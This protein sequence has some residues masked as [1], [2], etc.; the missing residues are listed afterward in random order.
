[1]IASVTGALARR[2]R[3][4]Y[5][6]HPER[7]R[8]LQRPVISIGNLS[9]GGTGKTPL[10]AHIARLL[11]QMGHLPAVLS[12][13]YGRPRA[14]DG[15]VVV[16][17]GRHVLAPYE[18]AG[19][20]PLMLARQ[21]P[22]CIV[23]VAADRFLAGALAERRLGCTVHLLDDGFQHLQLARALDL[24][25]VTGRDLDDR[26][27]PAGRLREPIGTIA[28]ADAVVVHAADGIAERAQTAGARRVFTMTRTIDERRGD[29]VFAFAGIGRPEGFF[30]ALAEGGWNVVG[31][32]AFPDHR[33]YGAADFARLADRAARAGASA[34]VTTE[35]DAARL[36]GLRVPTLPLIAVALAVTV[37]PAAA[38]SAMLQQACARG[39]A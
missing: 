5:A 26:V 38:F 30:D 2:R 32:M 15:A 31:R 23:V 3:A 10:V 16:S 11:Q 6:T 14:L 29:P 22:G 1:L 8:T 35:K 28:S 36:D 24:V 20:E 13:G 18:A 27:M 33:R 37:E 7:R 21:L 25:V 39:A 12:R 19:D 9:M 34:L 17:D 4:A